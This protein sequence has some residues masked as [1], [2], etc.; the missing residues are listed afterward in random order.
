MRT[1]DDAL[2]EQRLI[3]N[4]TPSSRIDRDQATRSLRQAEAIVT[5]MRR[6]FATEG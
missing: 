2:F 6:L 5:E 1:L 3:A 4:Y